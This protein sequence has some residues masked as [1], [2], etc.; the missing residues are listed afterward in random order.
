MKKEIKSFLSKL[1]I[2]PR[3]TSTH[4]DYANFV[5]CSMLP[6]MFND[7]YNKVN[8]YILDT[9]ERIAGHTP[10]TDPVLE[11]IELVNSVFEPLI[12]ALFIFKMKKEGFTI[13]DKQA[14]AE[15][16]FRHSSI[17]LSASL[18]GLMDINGKETIVEFKRS[19]I[20]KFE[21]I[22]EFYYPQIQ[23]QMMC[24]GIKT[25]YLVVLSKFSDEL[26]WEKIAYDDDWRPAIEKTVK[27]FWS[28]VNTR[29]S[30]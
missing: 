16:S 18:D 10:P 21:K 14:K 7:K 28:R 2:K 12:K 11:N 5:G 19:A 27:D 22:K 8:Q 29:E 17:K 30:F 15:K 26:S 23:G 24:T 4:T 13:K 1:V 25:V 3:L 6:S 9:R 20:S